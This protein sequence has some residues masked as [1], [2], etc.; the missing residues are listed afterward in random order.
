L[1]WIIEAAIDWFW[2]GFVERMSKGKPWWVFVLAA[3]FGIG[4]LLLSE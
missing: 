3:L 4:W 2:V 1:G